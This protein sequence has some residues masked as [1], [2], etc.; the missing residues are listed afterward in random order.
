MISE[1][2][3]PASALDLLRYMA[4]VSG[5][6]VFA[7]GVGFGLN[8][9]WATTAWPWP[10]GKFSYLFVGSVLAAAAAALIW[11]GVT[12]EWRVLVAGSLTAVVVTAGTAVYLFQVS[13]EAGREG[14]VL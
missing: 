12:A 3:N 7:L 13:Q 8:M 14:L 6:L 11:I 9:P 10:D 4:I 2:V 1:K 5:V